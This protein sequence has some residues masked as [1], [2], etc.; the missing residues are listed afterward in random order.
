M[1]V[2][3]A[4]VTGSKKCIAAFQ[5]ARERQ[6][7]GWGGGEWGGGGD[8]MGSGGGG[9]SGWGGER[10]RKR[11]IERAREREKKL[12]MKQMIERRERERGERRL[13]NTH[14]HIHT[15]THTHT[16]KHD[17][18]F[19]HDTMRQAF[20]KLIA[21]LRTCNTSTY[22]VYNTITYPD[23]QYNTTTSTYIVV[24]YYYIH[25]HSIQYY[26]ISRYTSHEHACMQGLEGMDAKRQALHP[27][28]LA[29]AV[30]EHRSDCVFGAAFGC[31]M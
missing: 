30:L 16:C 19:V 5:K 7:R 11:A 24:Q 6:R 31:C 27:H 1:N 10:E 20:W 8:G 26:H 23:I 17:G 25:I 12:K 14:T 9:G 29:S 21:D 18:R 2:I 28:A 4:S 15:H 22:I 3:L 13:R